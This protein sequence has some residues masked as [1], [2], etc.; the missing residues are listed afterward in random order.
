M[1][2][3][4]LDTEPDRAEG[5][6]PTAGQTRIF[7][8]TRNFPIYYLAITKCGCTYLKNLFHA[9]DH[10]VP[11]PDGVFV[12][13][14][15]SG[16]T[17]ATDIAPETIQRSPYAFAVLRE[18]GARFLSFYFDKIY[19][20]GPQ[21]FPE[22][23]AHLSRTIGLDLTP[24]LSVSGHRDNCLRLIDWV[25]RNLKGETDR[26]KNYHWRPQAARLRRAR[27]YPVTCL[28]LPGLD[29]QLPQLLAPVIP[30]LRA[31]MAAVHA[32]N[33]APRPVPMAELRTPELDA[34]IAETYA[35]DAH[36]YARAQAAWAGQ[37]STRRGTAWP[38]TP[39][40][41]VG[42]R[43]L[44]AAG[45]PVYLRTVSARGVLAARRWL[46]QPGRP[47]IEGD[48]T[49]EDRAIRLAVV[50][51]PVDRLLFFYAHGLLRQNRGARAVLSVLVAKRGFRRDPVASADHVHNL[52]ALTR[53]LQIRRAGLGQAL[54]PI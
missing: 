42:T 1:T 15:E 32:R 3:R 22:I 16:L 12:H 8:T 13:E 11:H 45:M 50:E 30:D 43:A 24:D 19:G 26:P 38:S 20:E 9:L 53:F 41:R 33:S 23:R 21:N 17:K 4:A 35:A 49:R 36:L 18:P 14:T 29:W 54:G 28:T 5:L 39:P 6:R 34:R 51:D 31:R 40:L 46:A 52:E 44:R 37:H 47:T 48:V 7:Y 27:G 10:G 25:T 2:A